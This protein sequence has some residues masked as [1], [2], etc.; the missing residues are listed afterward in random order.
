MREKRS[1]NESTSL[2]EKFLIRLLVKVLYVSVLTSFPEMPSV[3]HEQPSSL[4]FVIFS[5]LIA[6]QKEFENKPQALNSY[7]HN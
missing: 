1:S 3:N 6:S 5:F 7:V 4:N 2:Q